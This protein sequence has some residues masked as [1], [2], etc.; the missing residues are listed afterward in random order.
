ML[1]WYHSQ[2]RFQFESLGSKNNIPNV[3]LHVCACVVDLHLVLLVFLLG[4]LK[5]INLCISQHLKVL[6]ELVNSLLTWYKSQVRLQVRISIQVKVFCQA[7]ALQACT[8]RSQESIVFL[9]SKAANWVGLAW[10]LICSAWNL[11]LGKQYFKL[12]WIWELFVGPK[13]CWVKFAQ[14]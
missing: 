2:A 12:G 9:P 6:R 5:Y 13:W 3:V 7:L 10:S 11:G 1:T 14:V 8:E 4:L